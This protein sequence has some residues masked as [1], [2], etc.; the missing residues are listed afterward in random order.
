[1]FLPPPHLEPSWNLGP[2]D[3]CRSSAVSPL[4]RLSHPPRSPHSS[5]PPPQH[6]PPRLPTSVERQRS[7][8]P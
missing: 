5:S 4:S 3:R 7:R 8:T 6:P 1:M 2:N